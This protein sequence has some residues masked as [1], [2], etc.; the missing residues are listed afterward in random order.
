MGFH[1]FVEHTRCSGNFCHT[2][3]FIMNRRNK[4]E[5]EIFKLLNLTFKLF[6][7]CTILIWVVNNLQS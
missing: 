5:E 7:I 1:Y 4:D 6:V 3:F 2:L